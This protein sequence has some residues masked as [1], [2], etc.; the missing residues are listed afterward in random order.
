MS[1]AE[2]DHGGAAVQS[3]PRRHD[4]PSRLTEQKYFTFPQKYLWKLKVSPAERR[5]ARG[6]PRAAF[7]RWRRWIRWRRGSRC[8]SC[9]QGGRR[10]L[11]TSPGAPSPLLSH[12]HSPEA[13]QFNFM[14]RGIRPV[15]IV[16][17]TW[18]ESFLQGVRERARVPQLVMLFCR[19]WAHLQCFAGCTGRTYGT[20]AGYCVAGK[21]AQYGN[22]R[23]FKKI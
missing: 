10:R 12:C 16:T 22:I 6:G 3:V 15:T 17:L 20:T 21:R 9:R 8:W 2:D 18:E 23:P 19:R 7:W 14:Q 1:C 11:C 5:Q 13:R 4:L